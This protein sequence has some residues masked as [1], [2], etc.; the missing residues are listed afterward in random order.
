MIKKFYQS[1]TVEVE[2]YGVE[3]GFALSVEN[4]IGGPSY[5]EEDVEW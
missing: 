1:P 2:V 3:Q 5:D 4:G